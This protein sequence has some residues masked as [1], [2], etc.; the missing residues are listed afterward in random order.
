MLSVV[1]PT[2]NRS[3]Y[4]LNLVKLIGNQTLRPFEI[5]IVDSSDHPIDIHIFEGMELRIRYIYTTVKS[6]AIQRNIGLENVVEDCKFISFLDDDTCPDSDYFYRLITCLEKNKGI[7][8]SPL[9]KSTKK[10]FHRTKPK[11]LIGFIHKLFLLDSSKDGA[12]L[13]SAIGIP[14]RDSFVGVK[15]SQWLIGCSIWNFQ[16]VKSLRFEPD[17]VGQSLGED[18]I[19]SFRA[20][21]HGELFVD[22]N[23]TL[24]HS[25]A[26]ENRPDSSEFWK[27][28]V[29]NRHRLSKLIYPET[30]FLAGFHWANF[31]QVL[32]L[33]FS[34]LLNL[35]FCY[36][37]IYGF[38]LGY[39][40]LYRWKIT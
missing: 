24:F 28:W 2:R 14:I 8:I 12:I 29:T 37:V 40:E 19:F 33:I 16:R 15:A 26:S 20:S 9:V 27:M 23:T 5:I 4:L 22:T 13:A 25:E 31:G 7:G 34:S 35:K 1:I 36:E 6:A 17:F 30:K 39:S 3:P 18:V 11:G 10:S 38:T 32:I 21:Q